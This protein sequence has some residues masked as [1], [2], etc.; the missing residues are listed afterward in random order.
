MKIE[1]KINQNKNYLNRIIY[2][3]KNNYIE[4]HLSK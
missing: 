3:I 1:F 4:E 2:H